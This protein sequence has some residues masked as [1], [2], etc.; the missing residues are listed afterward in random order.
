MRGG[1]T[2]RCS[3]AVTRFFVS[4]GLETDWVLMAF[5][6]GEGRVAKLSDVC[7]PTMVHPALAGLG[8]HGQCL[9]LPEVDLVMTFVQ[10]RTPS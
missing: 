9:S 10:V 1:V 4:Q 2:G 7:T 8:G 3:P 5:I 6:R